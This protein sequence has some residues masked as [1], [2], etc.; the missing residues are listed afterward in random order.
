MARRFLIAMVTPEVLDLAQ[1]PIVLLA[2][3]VVLQVSSSRILGHVLCR[4]VSSN[5]DKY[6]IRWPA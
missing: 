2:I 4:T 5:T 1:F 3:F 6:A